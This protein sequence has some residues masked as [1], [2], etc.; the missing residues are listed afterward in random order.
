MCGVCYGVSF[1][2]SE[3]IFDFFQPGSKKWC[4]PKPE[5]KIMA[6]APP[7]FFGHS[8]RLILI[9][10]MLDMS[11]RLGSSNDQ[12]VFFMQKTPCA[13]LLHVQH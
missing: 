8:F 4:R 10:I 11:E 7:N 1:D 3:K 12:M 13:N 6:C 9:E 5:P 2:C